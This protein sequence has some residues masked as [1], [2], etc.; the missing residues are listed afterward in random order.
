M[1]NKNF[2]KLFVSISLNVFFKIMYAVY[3][4]L[5]YFIN[6]ILCQHDHGHSKNMYEKGECINKNVLW[7]KY[8]EVIVINVEN[9]NF[10]NLLRIILK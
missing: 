8:L 1:K 4:V 3:I 9:F 5:F 7:V 2:F 6:I 10:N